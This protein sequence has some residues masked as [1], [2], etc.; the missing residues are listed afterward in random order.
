MGRAQVN[1]LSGGVSRGVRSSWGQQFVDAT[2]DFFKAGGHRSSGTWRSP[3]IDVSLFATTLTEGAGSGAA[4]VPPDVQP[5]PIPLPTRALRMAELFG[6]GQTGSNTVRLLMESAYTN[7]AAPTAEGAA[8]PESALVFSSTDERV[9]KI[10]H[11]LP[12]TDEMLEDVPTI[13]SYIDSRLRLGVLLAEDDQLLNGNGTAPNLLGVLNRS[14]LTPTITQTTESVA[15]LVATQAAAVATAS[16]LA[17]DGVVLHPS[18]WLRILTAK[19]STGRYLSEGAPFVSVNPPL[20]WDL[21]AVTTVAIPQKTILVGN[22][23]YGGIVFRHTSGL[24]VESTNSH[25]DWFQKN[26]VAIRAEERLALAIV[27]SS[28]FGKVVLA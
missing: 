27:R 23:A 13:S 19:D 16:N 10:A 15:D 8:K 3:A 5:G 21:P 24:R 14:G 12:V 25:Q 22:F 20:I 17:P 9:A 1:A 6:R 11:F 7:S 26:I 4:L 28:A 2:R 18:D